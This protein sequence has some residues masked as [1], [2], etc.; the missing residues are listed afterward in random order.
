[1]SGL[2]ILKRQVQKLLDT[3]LFG[4]GPIADKTIAQ[5][6]DVLEDHEVR[7]NRME[8]FIREQSLIRE[9]ES[10]GA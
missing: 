6:V 10:D 7:L 5:A 8:N 9:K 3:P 4:K 2:I 1:M